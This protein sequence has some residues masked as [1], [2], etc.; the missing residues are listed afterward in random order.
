MGFRLRLEP[1]AQEEI[2][3]AVDWYESQKS[4]LGNQFLDYLEGYFKIVKTGNVLFQIKKPPAFR[5][6]PLKKFL[7]V[8]IY[9]IDRDTIV[10]YS[11]FNTHQNRVYDKFPFFRKFCIL[12]GNNN[13]KN[14][15][16]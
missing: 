10:V 5:E 13:P 11:L 4:G 9:E 2:D 16:Q 12:R 7:F 8:I 3:Q 6:L 15:H 1:R 14:Q